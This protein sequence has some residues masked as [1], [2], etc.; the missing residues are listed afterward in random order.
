MSKAQ[1]FLASSPSP[2]LHHGLDSVQRYWLL[3]L[4]LAFPVLQSALF[5]RGYSLLIALFAIAGALLAE[6]P[7]TSHGRVSRLLN[8]SALVQGLLFSLMLPA[9][10]ALYIPFFSCFLSSLLVKYLLGGVSASWLSV[11]LFAFLFARFAWPEAFEGGKTL[12]LLYQLEIS[13]A[14]YPHEG[15]V[16]PLDILKMAGFKPSAMDASVT[17]FINRHILRGLSAE[18]PFGYV[19][20]L[21]SRDPGA[22]LADRGCFAL[23]LVSPIALAMRLSRFRTAVSFLVPYLILVFLFEPRLY[24][25]ASPLSIAR[26]APGGSGDV[27]FSL[28]TGGS[29]LCAVF[30]VQDSSL[31]GLSLLGSS[32]LAF[33]SALIAFLLRQVLHIP[34]G[35]FHAL[36]LLS[37]LAPPLRMLEWHLAR[38]L[39]AVRRRTAS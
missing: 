33:L 13:H 20:M 12:S 27:L 3:A 32:L 21:F 18:L 8:G 30:L 9:S 38:R 39:R 7:G 19:D 16:H 5:D 34:Y 11:P 17:R 26:L 24:G 15:S 4:C 10:I 1:E 35:M 2:H 29:V 6:L 36:I 31:S 23:L 14:R 25:H 37:L 22:I 28:L